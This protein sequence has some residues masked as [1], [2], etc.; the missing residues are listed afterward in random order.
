VP[1]PLK[2][3]A[4]WAATT[5]CYI[6]CDYFELYVPGKLQGM[7]DGRMGP[8]GQVTQS[9]LVGTSAMLI[10]PSLMIVLS[11]TLPSAL[12]R[13]LNLLFG[14]CYTLSMLLLAYGIGWYFYKLFAL[15]EAALTAF[16]FW[17]ALQWPRVKNGG[18]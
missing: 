14:V 3:S 2:L 11:V 12:N 16:I 8:L 1:I 4:A 6:Y 15:I 10:I 9:I 5:L 7:L 13:A 17:M 18:G